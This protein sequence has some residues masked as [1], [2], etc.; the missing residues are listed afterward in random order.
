MTESGFSPLDAN[1]EPTPNGSP[2]ER[3]TTYTYAMLG[4]R[5]DKQ[6]N[7]WN[8]LPG[9]AGHSVLVAIDGPLP[10]GPK[11]SPEDSD[12]T[13]LEWDA[14]G[15]RISKITK[16][17][18]QATTF[19][20]D[21]TTLPVMT[22]IGALPT[23][24][25]PADVNPSWRMVE[26]IDAEGAA[27][28]YRYNVRGQV[29]QTTQYQGDQLLGGI[30]LRYDAQ[31]RAV[32]HTSLLP[33]ASSGFAAWWASNDNQL[34][35]RPET[36]R[37]FDSIGRLLWQVNRFGVLKQ[38]RY[39]TEGNLLSSRVTAGGMT[40]AERYSYDAMGQL[41]EVSDA[42][43]ATRRLLR[44]R[45]GQISAVVDPLGRV[46]TY[47]RN[48]AE[49]VMQVTQ[50][51]NTAQP[52]T[53]RYEAGASGQIEAVT[54]LSSARQAQASRS[55]KTRFLHDDFGR[56]VRT[57][58]A[59]SGRVTRQFN[60]VDQL[61]EVRDAKGQVTRLS[62][63]A[64]GRVTQ[65]SVQ[66]ADQRYVTDY[67]YQANRLVEVRDPAQ[68]ERFSY[69]AQGR[70]TSRQVSLQPIE[71]GA[72]ITS[73]TRY[74]YDSEGHLEAQTLPDGSELHYQ[75]NRQGQIVAL[76]RQAAAWLPF[77]WGRSTLISA[78]ERDL[79]GLRQ[80][81]FGNGIKTQWQR[82]RE[83]VLARVVYTRPETKAPSSVQAMVESMLPVAA[84]STPSATA[85]TTSSTSASAPGAYGITADPRTLWDD[86]LLFDA[87]GN[88]VQQ[89]QFA[90]SAVAAPAQVGYAYDGLNQL[91]QAVVRAQ[92]KA[93]AKSVS[94]TNDAKAASTNVWRYHHDSLGNRLLA[95]QTTSLDDMAHTVATSYEAQSNQRAD[96]QL[97]AAGNL[98]QRNARGYQW[99]AMG[100]LSS[101]T[102]QGEPVARYRYNQRG[103]RI[104]KQVKQT[105]THYLYNER[106]QRIAEL[107]AQGQINKQYVWMADQL[108]AVIDSDK[109]IA[110]SNGDSWWSGLAQTAKAIWQAATGP[111][112]HIHYVHTNHLGAPIAMTDD[113]AKPIWSATYSPFGERQANG[114][115]TASLELR[116]PGQ[117]QDQESGLYYNDHRYY[118]PETGRYISPDPLG[119]QGGLNSYA[120]VSNNPIGFSNPLGLILFAFD[121]T[122]N[123]SNENNGDKRDFTNVYWMNELYD[124]DA[125]GQGLVRYQRGIGTDPNAWDI[126]NNIQRAIATEGHKLVTAQ[127]ENLDIYVR[128]LEEPRETVVLDVIGFSRGA[129]LAR[130]FAN[131]VL[132]KYENKEY[133]QHCLQFRFMGLFDTVSQFGINASQDGEYN[134][135][136]APEW[137]KVSQAYALNEHRSLFPLRSINRGTEVGF[138]G[139]HSDIGG[140]YN[141]D[142]EQFRGDLSD[143]ALNWM[144][145]QAKQA[146]V[147][148]TNTPEDLR[149]VSNPVVHD[150]RNTSPFYGSRADKKVF[151]DDTYPDFDIK[152]ADERKVIKPDG[153]RVSQPAF[154]GSDP[155][156]GRMMEKLIERPEGWTTRTDNCAGQV[157]M[158]SYRAWLKANRGFE[159]ASATNEG[160]T[161]PCK[162]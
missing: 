21:A 10:N 110:L 94:T 50:A 14:T 7:D 143:V 49:R 89:R 36:L 133:G 25:E 149:T 119:L 77:G 31:G 53:V 105:T 124:T 85:A 157:Y 84:A 79:V 146:G 92:A 70:V 144:L 83:G 114:L 62:Y 108:I 104:S 137:E 99:D 52:L 156:W 19:S 73:I 113:E 140:G 123:N 111:S 39:D 18:G 3:I 138:I 88:I 72:A 139:A 74:R 82:S 148:F 34:T 160:T 93:E 40:Q 101:I 67:V 112:T 132:N 129:A 12:I 134:F 41:A 45:D 121:G 27:T 145:E 161:Q 128:S 15:T 135:D 106:R 29:L 125:A 87:A 152:P 30:A 13:T 9:H 58:S 28:R 131:R 97:D 47:E 109:P 8:L 98:K 64:Q 91:M 51:A 5:P 44:G 57:E 4:Q 16:P 80:A 69:D 118:D 32:E 95:Q 65:R 35:Q 159:I 127:L 153:S 75:R 86:R 17:M 120:Y 78:L 136:I 20:Y 61:V 122:G 6:V 63:D 66:G 26:S 107:N 130:D 155:T 46:T 38:A 76:Q 147:K 162:P 1:G 117:W 96:V 100:R 116:L 150:Q 151:R 126:T 142:S 103:E 2:I 154:A 48:E 22:A 81:T 68:T 42:T 24:H 33:K 55:V 11:N 141:T 23:S 59:D 115:Q 90:S 54:A 102:E 56:E 158:T 71:G 37:E 43:G 60:A